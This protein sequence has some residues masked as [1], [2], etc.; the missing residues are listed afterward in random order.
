MI[1][2]DPPRPLSHYGRSKWLAE[3][4]V[5]ALASRMQTVIV[6]PCMFYGPPVPERHIEI[7]RRIQ[8][9]RMPLV[10]HGH[11]ARSVSHIDNLVQ[12][13]HLAL[14]HPSAPGGT[15]YI[16]DRPIYTTRDI[17]DAM[18][19]ALDAP[20]R[21]MKIPAIVA[22]TAFALDRLL[23]A[24]GIYW[25]TL[26]LVGEAD[27]HVGVSCE[28]AIRELGYS[29]TIELAEGMQQAVRWCLETGRLASTKTA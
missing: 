6:R 14:T 21:W 2:S 11:Y 29:P 3:T 5:N 16:V 24:V 27:W 10:G 18:A 12:G 28:K 17:V 4:A 22:P 23:A 26:H 7:Y 9:G 8:S 20:I 19:T 25:Q 15:Y 13:C 1:E